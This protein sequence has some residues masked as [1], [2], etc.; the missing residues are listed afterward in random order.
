MLDR[1]DQICS[2][3]RAARAAKPP[4]HPARPPGKRPSRSKKL[5]QRI[6]KVRTAPASGKL[7][8]IDGRIQGGGVLSIVRPCASAISVQGL[9]VGRMQPAAAEID[10]IAAFVHGPR[11]AAEPVARLDDEAVDARI[12]QPPPGRDAGR[13]AADDHDLEVALRHVDAEVQFAAVASRP[14]LTSVATSRSAAHFNKA[15]SA[16]QSACPQ[17]VR[18]YSTLGGT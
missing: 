10:R 3:V 16:G 9:S 14:L 4:A 2:S 12:M 6:A 5:Q 17:S 13:A 15:S 1:A 7:I 18:Q 8:G 11:P